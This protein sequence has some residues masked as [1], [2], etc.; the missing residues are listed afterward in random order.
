[1]S[2]TIPAW[3]LRE[4]VTIAP[5]EG[6]KGVGGPAYGSPVTLRAHVE[7]RKRLLVLPNGREVRSEMFALVAPGTVAPPESRLTYNGRAYRVLDTFDVPSPRGGV[8][9]IEIALA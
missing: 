6:D 4:D 9:H 3:M 1:M 2:L 7:P 5:Y 8:H